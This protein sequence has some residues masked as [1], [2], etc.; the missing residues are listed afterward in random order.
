MKFIIFNHLKKMM[1]NF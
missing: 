1:S